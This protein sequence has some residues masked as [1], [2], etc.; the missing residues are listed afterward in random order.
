MTGSLAQSVM[1]GMKIILQAAIWASL[2]CSQ[3]S[4]ENSSPP[5]E[6]KKQ[7]KKNFKI[8]SAEIL[9]KIASTKTL[10]LEAFKFLQVDPK[11]GPTEKP[12]LIFQCESQVPITD[13]GGERCTFRC[14][15]SGDKR[16]VLTLYED[17]AKAI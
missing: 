3:A 15:A 12:Q 5:I 6:C 16:A 2:I 7:N 17:F 13:D 9:K 10:N 4:A 1:I 11:N 14:S 8:K